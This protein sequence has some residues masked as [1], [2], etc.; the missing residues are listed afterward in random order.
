ML[1]AFLV[2]LNGHCLQCGHRL[3]WQLV[4]ETA[5]HV[6]EN[7]MLNPQKA[8]E[9]EAMLKRLRELNAEIAQ[10]ERNIREG[11]ARLPIEEQLELTSRRLIE[12]QIPELAGKIGVQVICPAGTSCR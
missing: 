11:E 6:M 5:A 9:R 7:F 10:H 4:K 1:L 2:S 12:A 3:A 8:L